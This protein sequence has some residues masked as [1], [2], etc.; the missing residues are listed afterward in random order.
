MYLLLLRH[1]CNKNCFSQNG[2]FLNINFKD[3]NLSKLKVQKDM[4]TNVFMLSL[5]T[6]PG[7]P[8]YSQPGGMATDFNIWDR[9]MGDEELIEWT[10]CR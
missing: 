10:T 9:S 4:L 8:G 6:P 7:M 2:Q 1:N 5:N 3:D